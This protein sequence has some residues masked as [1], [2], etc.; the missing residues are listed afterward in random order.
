MAKNSNQDTAWDEDAVFIDR[1]EVSDFNPDNILPLS[2][3]K[4]AK[5]REWLQPT[6]YEGEDS[7]FKKHLSARLAGTGKWLAESTEYKDWHDGDHSGLLWI[8]GV[9]QLTVF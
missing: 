1:D 9:H 4:L 7:A 3:D 2:A 5:I 6:E 8:R